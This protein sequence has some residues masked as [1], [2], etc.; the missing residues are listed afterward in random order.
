[1]QRGFNAL[2]LYL[3]AART[4]VVTDCV[5]TCTEGAIR[6]CQGAQQFTASAHTALS[7]LSRKAHSAEEFP[8]SAGSKHAYGPR[9]E[10]LWGHQRNWSSAA[11]PELA[12]QASSDDIMLTESAIQKIRELLR[13]STS[14][15]KFMRLTVEAGGCSGF[16]YKF[17]FGSQLDPTDRI[18][19]QK[20]VQ[21]VVD[22][23]SLEFVRGA[24]VDY[25]QELIKSTF[26]VVHNPNAEGGCGC[27]SSFNPK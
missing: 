15:E 13:D 21:L 12:T 5:H 19:E 25:L 16:S 7:I 20:G 2:H 18:F 3:R 8:Y 1:M 10:S 26:E 14:G 9:L 22:D 11:L 27:G 4:E 24:T 23:V 6:A 17:D